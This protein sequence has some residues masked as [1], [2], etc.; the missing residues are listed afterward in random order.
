MHYTDHLYGKCFK[1]AA[2]TAEK[3]ACYT[4]FYQVDSWNRILQNNY[5]I[6]FLE[7]HSH[8]VTAVDLMK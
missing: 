5:E 3:A 4:F 8:L 2:E 6:L 1:K 7:A